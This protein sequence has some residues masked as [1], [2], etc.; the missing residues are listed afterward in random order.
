[1]TSLLVLLVAQLAVAQDDSAL[2][3]TGDVRV[4]VGSLSEFDVDAD[5]TTLGQGTRVDS[6]VRL[7]LQARPSTLFQLNAELD[8]L[9]GQLAGDTWTL[10]DTFDQRNRDDYAARGL[11]GVAPR[12]ASVMTVLGSTQVELGLVSS[13][14][15]LGMVANNGAEDPMFGRANFADRV[16]RIRATALPVHDGPAPRTSWLVTG[17]VDAV[18]ADEIGVWA[19]GQRGFQGVFSVLGLGRRGSQV[20]AYSALRQQWEAQAGRST[21]A[22]VADVFVDGEKELGDWTL[23]TAAEGATVLGRTSRATTYSARDQ[24]GVQSLGLTGIATLSAPKTV[25]IHGR[26]G[27][28][29]GDGAPDDGVSHDFAFDRNF[30]VGM[31]LFP[32]VMGGIEAG[33][34]ALLLDPNI[35]G[36]P[37]DGVDVLTTEGAFRKAVF[38][39]PVVEVDPHDWVDVK[40]G[41]V[42]AFGTAPFA[43]PFYSYR[44][45]GVARTHLNTPSEGRLL[46]TELNWSLGLERPLDDDA[47]AARPG[48]ELQGGHLLPG[49]ALGGSDVGTVH[50][51]TA[52]ARLRG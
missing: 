20:G 46:G 12:R 37:P 27:Y 39:S 15:G 4:L 7:G 18:V 29:S 11:A 17:A 6:R 50:L 19:D 35:S 38:V 52:M 31:V 8:A 45:G 40:L 2:V 16:V 3:T 25:S 51:V 44:A 32:E 24:V 36:Q 28:A 9:T 33:T 41:A 30:G 1:M 42:W 14:W 23:R 13:N 22:G 21:T 43:Q 10:T 34:Q 49:G 47:R 26:F 5:G 48:V